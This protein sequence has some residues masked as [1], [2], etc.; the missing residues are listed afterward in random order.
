MYVFLPDG[1]HRHFMQHLRAGIGELAQLGVSSAVD[2][3]GIVDDMRVGHQ[4]AGNV[5]PIFIDAGIQRGSGQCA[6]DVRAA[7]GE[8]ADLA[9]GHQTV[10]AG[11]DDLLGRF[12]LSDATDIALLV[13]TGDCFGNGLFKFPQKKSVFRSG[14]GNSDA[15][16][17]GSSRTSDSVDVVFQISRDIIIEYVRDAF[18]IKTACRNI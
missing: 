11:N 5:R 14:I 4:N 17:A 6:R 7:A 8:R 15:G 1:E 18:D 16:C 9:V 2:G 3:L 13:I 10:E 12:S